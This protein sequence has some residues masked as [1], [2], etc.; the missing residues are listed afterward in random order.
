MI[1]E[2]PR[3]GETFHRVVVGENRNEVLSL[4]L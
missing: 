4:L 1:D 3:E 2:I